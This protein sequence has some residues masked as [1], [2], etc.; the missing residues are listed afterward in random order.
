MAFLCLFEIANFIVLY[1]L[2][3]GFQLQNNLYLRPS[4]YF[5]CRFPTVWMKY[6]TLLVKFYP[7]TIS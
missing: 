5:G 2:F 4:V 3:V 1:Q 6:H 7:G